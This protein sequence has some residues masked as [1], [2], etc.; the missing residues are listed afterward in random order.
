[1]GTSFSYEHGQGSVSE[2]VLSRE[3]AMCIAVGPVA[4]LPV[5]ESRLTLAANRI[6]WAI[7]IECE[8]YARISVSL[9][10]YF[11]FPVPSGS[12]S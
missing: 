12:G 6:G 9:L 10:D 7:N 8:R 5:L 11:S 4:L 3:Q 2:K 1:M